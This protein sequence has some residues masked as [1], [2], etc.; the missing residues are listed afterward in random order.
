MPKLTTFRTVPNYNSYC[1]VVFSRGHYRGIRQDK[2]WQ[3]LRGHFLIR[4]SISNKYC[5][6][7]RQINI[8]LSGSNMYLEINFNPRLKE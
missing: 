1:V 7:P 8:K 4:M 3:V 5:H 6:I 2:S